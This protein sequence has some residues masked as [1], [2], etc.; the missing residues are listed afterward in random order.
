MPPRGTSCPRCGTAL[1]RSGTLP[2]DQ[3]SIRPRQRPPESVPP[4]RAAPGAV[5]RE[6]DVLAGWDEDVVSPDP[7]SLGSRLLPRHLG[8][9]VATL[10]P[11]VIVFSG[12]LAGGFVGAMLGR[13]RRSLAAAVGTLTGAG[14]AAAG[15]AA[16]SRA[17]TDRGGENA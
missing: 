3:D 17:A 6:G 1:T 14:T 5:P 13:Q 16:A 2:A 8:R 9:Q 11:V 12:A 15:V 7:A 4:L 10:P